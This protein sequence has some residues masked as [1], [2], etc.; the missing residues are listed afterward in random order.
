MYGPG[1]MRQEVAMSDAGQ[2]SG[3]N[4]RSVPSSGDE[5][6]PLDHADREVM[7][8]SGPGNLRD[9][10]PLVDEDGDDIREYTGEP[11]ETD[12]GWVVPQTQ[13]RG[14]SGSEVDGGRS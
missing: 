10:E 14:D 12:E 5:G 8:P 3:V 7:V 6:D 2:A 4:E 11:V 9:R 13:N 1:S